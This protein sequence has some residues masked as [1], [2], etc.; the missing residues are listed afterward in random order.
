MMRTNILTVLIILFAGN[1][2]AGSGSVSSPNAI[3]ISNSKFAELKGAVLIEKSRQQTVQLKR[4]L[5]HIIANKDNVDLSPRLLTLEEKYAKLILDLNSYQQNLELKVSNLP[6][7]NA[8]EQIQQLHTIIVQLQEESNTAKSEY[9]Q[10]LTTFAAYK[11]DVSEIQASTI[12]E[13]NANGTALQR[14]LG[15]LEDRLTEQI[16]SNGTNDIL[17]LNHAI[18][19]QKNYL[20]A[21]ISMIIALVVAMFFFLKKQIVTLK[22]DFKTDQHDFQQ[23]LKEEGVGL[24]QKL[25]EIIETQLTIQNESNTSVKIPATEEPDHSLALKVADEIVRI[26]KNISRMDKKTKG[27]KQ[28]AASVKRIQD[29]FAS[30]GYEVVEMLGQPYKEGMKVQANFIPDDELEEGQEIITRIIKPQVNFKGE[31]IQSAQIEV[32]QG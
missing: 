13:N 11:Q 4:L 28:L 10:L 29:N 9:Q 21:T 14:E 1:V 8:A 24:D 15:L 5:N 23:S 25:V 27:L 3:D 26:Q 7:E 18:G 31:M 17:E 22:A 6:N 2:H 16:G 12:K 19:Q 32:S 30:N 20:I